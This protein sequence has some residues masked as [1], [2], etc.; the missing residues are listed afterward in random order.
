MFICYDRE[1]S[2]PSERSFGF[3]GDRAGSGSVIMSPKTG[4][5][6]LVERKMSS[7]LNNG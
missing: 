7:N 1:N 4:L 6:E 2:K 3:S 5:S